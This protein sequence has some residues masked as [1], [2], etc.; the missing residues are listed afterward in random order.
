MGYAVL[1]NDDLLAFADGAGMS[2]LRIESGGDDLPGH[3][4]QL[5]MHRLVTVEA[6]EPWP[7]L[8]IA[9]KTRHLSKGWILAPPSKRSGL[10]GPTRRQLAHE[11]M[12][13]QLLE[14]L[15]THP[16]ASDLELRLGWAALPHVHWAAA[17]AFPEETRR[18]EG[19][20]RRGA[21]PARIVARRPG[22][23]PFGALL[24]WLASSPDRKWVETP[25]EVVLTR[26]QV[27]VRVP[28]GVSA[29]SP[30]TRCES[31]SV[32]STTTPS[33]SS[34]AVRGSC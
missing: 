16:R 21:G 13:V 1:L 12:V 26:E 10:G 15:S 33:T 34:G 28:R 32:P 3:G 8:R 14:A 7:A 29:A 4:T 23:T 6:V 22:P 9:W 25:G 5:R 19:A 11:T 18:G 24:V 31:A 2:R 17:E 20:F 30:G 27:F